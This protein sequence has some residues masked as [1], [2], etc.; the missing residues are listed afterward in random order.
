MGDAE[1]CDGGTWRWESAHRG[2]G[3]QDATGGCPDRDKEAQVQSGREG[4]VPGWRVSRGQAAPGGVVGSPDPGGDAPA[5]GG[6][7]GLEA[8]AAQR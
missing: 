7:L 5:D 4:N 2:E 8:A 1:G 3:A 6:E